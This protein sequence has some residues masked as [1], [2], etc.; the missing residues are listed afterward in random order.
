LAKGNRPAKTVM[1]QPL[2]STHEVIH[3]PSSGNLRS[4]QHG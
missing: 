4:S 2:I 1:D 3:G